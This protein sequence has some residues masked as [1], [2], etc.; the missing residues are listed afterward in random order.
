MDF[1][2]SHS[3]A[4]SGSSGSYEIDVGELDELTL[5]AGSLGESGILHSSSTTPSTLRHRFNHYYHNGR[6]RLRGMRHMSAAKSGVWPK[7][8]T[9]AEKKDGKEDHQSLYGQL[10]YRNVCM[11]EDLPLSVAISPTRQCVAFGCKAGV[12]L[13]W[14][15]SR[16]HWRVQC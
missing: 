1:W 6:A 12:E 4:P 15:S 2:A 16:S 11:Q 3:L 13:Y 8:I 7:D 14:V 9:L 5:N 10:I